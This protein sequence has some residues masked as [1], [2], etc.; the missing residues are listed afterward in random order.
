VLV[1]AALLAASVLPNPPKLAHLSNR[2]LGAI[3]AQCHSP[4]NWLR[5]GPTGEL[6]IRPSRTA[7][8]QQVDCILSKLKLRGA[9]PIGF[10]GNELPSR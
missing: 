1:V 4:R 2:E 10:V 5:Y 3:S 6:H 8:Y 7:K 9:Q